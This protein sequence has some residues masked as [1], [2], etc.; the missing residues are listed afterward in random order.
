[1][2]LE[3]AKAQAIAEMDEA[4]ALRYAMED[5]F[6]VLKDAY[7]QAIAEKNTLEGALAA[8]TVPVSEAS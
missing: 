6:A 8:A 1:K 4:D 3:D 7:D 5:Q 2:A